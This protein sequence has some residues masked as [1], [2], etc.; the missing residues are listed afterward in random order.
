MKAAFR[1]AAVQSP[2]IPLVG[3]LVRQQP[4]TISLGQG[5]VNYGPPRRS[6]D[7]IERFLSDPA[8][9][10]YKMVEGI[11]ELLNLIGTKL[12]TENSITIDDRVRIVVT[13]G[14]NMAFMNALLAI[15]DPGDEII[16]IVPFYF[17]HEMAVNIAGCIPVFVRS[18]EQ[19]G[20]RIEAIEAAITN[21]TRA[22]VTISPNNP[23][24]AVYSQNSLQRIN[25]LC[26]DRGIFHISDEAYEYFT[27]E[28]AT[29]YSP[30]AEAGS[31]DHTISLFSLSKAYGFASWRIGWMVLP[32]ALFES[33]KKIQDTNLICPPVISQW[34]AAGALA[35][36]R[37]YCD[38]RIESLG[39]VRRKVLATLQSIAD[40]VSV[41]VTHG[42]FYFLIKVKT[43]IRD[44]DLVE[45][46]IRDHRIAAMPGS[47]F[48]C[49]DGCYLRL[50]YGALEPDSVSEGISRFAEGIRSIC[51]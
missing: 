32:E 35:E 38:A 49:N 19:Y 33:V 41:P 34:A 20:P 36:G 46:L 23:T 18:D 7:N 5:V 22:V 45:R 42:A 26:R 3:E 15:A 10:R 21:R 31:E 27:Y 17:N 24:G 12:S 28:N 16:L 11:P 50:A 2:I 25:Q 48:G 8:N 13:A 44:L 6:I 47:P 39:P 9:H 4:G 1:M 30:A 14:S 40:L 51:A 37:G 43:E 29:H